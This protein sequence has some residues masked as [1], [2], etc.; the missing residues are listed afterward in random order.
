MFSN[1]HSI[2]VWVN[3]R[4]VSFWVWSISGSGHLVVKVFFLIQVIVGWIIWVLVISGMHYFIRN[5][6][7]I[8]FGF[9][10]VLGSSQL[11]FG[12]TNSG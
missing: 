3:F 11:G 1:F 5:Y 10:S 6:S 4:F 7:R 8:F 12:L 9:E 2:F